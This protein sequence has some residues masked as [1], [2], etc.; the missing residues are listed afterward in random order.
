[1]KNTFP[2]HM[3]APSDFPI[4]KLTSISGNVKIEE[5]LF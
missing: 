3:A 5:L 1:M 4:V 2:S